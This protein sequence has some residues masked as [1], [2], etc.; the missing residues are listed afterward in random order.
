MRLAFDHQAFCLQTTGGISRYFCRLAE[1][2]I[3]L[4]QEVKVFAP[5]YRNQYL[6]K[7]VVPVWGRYLK[8]YPVKTANLL[9]ELNG[10]LSRHLIDRWH[11][12]VV[13]ETYFSGQ[14]SSPVNTPSILTVFDMI[15]ELEAIRDVPHAASGFKVSQKYKSVA[16]ADHVICISEHTRQDLI[17][18]F[19]V[20]EE[21]TSVIH[22]GC[23]EFSLSSASN[24]VH[25]NSERPFLLYVGNRN[26]YKNFALFLQSVASSVKLLNDFDIVAFG[27]GAFNPS[28]RLN[29]ERLGFRQNQVRQLT[30]HDEVLGSLYKTARAFVYPSTYEGFGLPPIEAMAMGCPVISSNASS[31]PEIIGNAACFFDPTSIDD[32]RH[33]IESVV[34]SDSVTQDLI[35]KGVARARLFTWQRCAQKTLEV[36][37]TLLDSHPSTI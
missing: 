33:A 7:T 37:Q 20:P 35:N 28:E 31:M 32:M 2:L 3:K 16:R 17:K 14:G 34:Y 9:V 18:L 22:L 15:S 4:R 27:G 19:D 23:D 24:F 10:L 13:H 8:K 29:I 36:Y 30:G 12:D 1:E 21:K 5:L 25:S 26:G 6:P 11:P